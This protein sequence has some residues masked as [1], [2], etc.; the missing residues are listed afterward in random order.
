MYIHSC[1]LYIV[2]VQIV[3]ESPRYLVL[4]GQ[5]H[6]AQSLLAKIARFN[7]K[8]SLFARLQSEGKKEAIQQLHF[9]VSDGEQEDAEDQNGD[10]DNEES[11]SPSPV[12][13]AGH[14]K[15]MVKR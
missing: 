9:T 12:I 3:P 6:K 7:C 4:K 8:P 5:T 11:V 13:V 10:T 15:K 1:H 14:Q 2:C